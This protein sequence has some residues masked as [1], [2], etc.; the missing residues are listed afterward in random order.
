MRYELS[1]NEWTAIKPMLPSKQAARGSDGWGVLP[2]CETAVTVASRR[3]AAG[4]RS[5]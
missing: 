1:V 4:S 5:G 3:D 2:K